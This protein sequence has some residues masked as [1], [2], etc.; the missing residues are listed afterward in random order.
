MTN[1]DPGSRY[2]R[3]ALGVDPL[4]EPLGPDELSALHAEFRRHLEERVAAPLQAGLDRYTDALEAAVSVIARLAESPPESAGEPES[5]EGTRSAARLRLRYTERFGTRFRE[6]LFEDA[7]E[8]RR[9]IFHVLDRITGAPVPVPDMVRAAPA[10]DRVVAPDLVR[11][12]WGQRIMAAVGKPGIRAVPVGLLADLYLA[13]LA[14][15]LEPVAN[16]TARL[17]ALAVARVRRLLH[18]NIELAGEDDGAPGLRATADAIAGQ[19]GHV[20]EEVQQAFGRALHAAAIDV[21]ERRA[22]SLREQAVSRRER[23]LEEWSEFEKALM[24]NVASENVLARALTAMEV[25]V[26]ETARDIER[27]RDAEGFVP[28]DEL[29]EGVTELADRARTELSAGDRNEILNRLGRR[30]TTLFDTELPRIERLTHLLSD[31]IAGLTEELDAIPGMVPDDLQVSEHP[32]PRI[33]ERPRSL[34]LREAP[35]EE[36]LRTACSGSLPRWAERSVEAAGEELGALGKELQRIR[37]AVE[38]HLK[39]PTRGGFTDAETRDLVVGI[40]ERVVAQIEDLRAQGLVSVQA[41]VDGLEEQSSSEA[42]GLRSA[43]ANREFLRI[44]SEIAEE[45]AVRQLSTGMERARA[46]GAGIGQGLRRAWDGA[47]RLVAG[48]QD[49]AER[50]LGVSEVEREEMLESLEQSLLGEDRQVSALPTMYRQLFDVEA[51]VP[52]DELLVPREEELAV[53]QRAFERWQDGLPAAVA[54]VGEKGSGKTTLVHLARETVFADA[55]VVSTA[56]GQ[57]I[58]SGAELEARLR[59]LFQLDRAEPLESAL[60][61]QP[62]TV[63]IVEDLH[64]LFIRALHG[65]DTLEGF[66][67]IISATR[68]TILWV[69][70]TEEVAWRYLD[71]VVGLDVHFS[72]TV[73]TTELSPK[74]LEQ[75]VMSR[76]DV[77]GF[78]LRFETRSE[79]TEGRGWRR[80][81]RRE[82]RGELTRREEQR[83]HYFQELAAIAEG[84]IVLALFY[85]LRSI[86][87]I[88]DHVLVMGDPE[89]IDLEFLERLPLAHLHTIAATILHGGIS[90]KAHRR[91]FQLPAM[92]TRLQLAALADSHMI[93]LSEDGEYKINKVL[94]RPFIR[95]LAA[96]NIL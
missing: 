89:I 27:L 86:K 38:F 93:F 15:R 80:F 45:Q 40:T 84:N 46:L 96:R 69:V 63:A 67:E 2:L 37:N 31:E 17:L 10:G 81:L 87:R 44:H 8:A 79:E 94:Y 82:P 62:P 58:E 25:A 23:L 85:W 54:V 33:P 88:E 66:L 16:D 51:G 35:L 50:Q 75:A 71:R 77:S 20:L 90:E 28:L 73:S 48:V 14:R 53:V 49:W 9:T 1:P 13:E 18:E 11:P 59:D 47:G 26:G 6:S 78:A 83:K 39:A 41:I 61:A 29:V 65:F 21:R 52:W 36:L 30:A 4:G 22:A 92:E 72:H 76:H 68:R 57:T 74:R 34:Q 19:I 55:R 43:V 42:D 70:T 12:A 5:I 32:V 95:L 24:A 60:N 56:L 7:A 64:N 3:E 91:I